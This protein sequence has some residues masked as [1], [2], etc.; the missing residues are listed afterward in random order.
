[1]VYNIKEYYLL[2]IKPWYN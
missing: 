1:V 2:L